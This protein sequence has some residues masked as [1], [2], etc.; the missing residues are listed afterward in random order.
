[1]VAE[2]MNTE[3]KSLLDQLASVSREIE[4]ENLAI[5]VA[6]IHC[7]GRAAST[8]SK[9]LCRWPAAQISAMVSDRKCSNAMAMPNFPDA[10]VSTR[11]TLPLPCRRIP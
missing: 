10:F 7:S 2:V 11:T 1:M 5:I 4:T 8:D 6:R 3:H 9:P